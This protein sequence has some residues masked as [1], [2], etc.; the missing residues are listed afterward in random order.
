MTNKIV[1]KNPQDYDSE[2]VQSRNDPLS[3]LL[4]LTKLHGV[5]PPLNW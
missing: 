3:I 2:Y 5:K 1:T 4:S